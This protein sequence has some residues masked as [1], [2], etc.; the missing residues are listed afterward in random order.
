MYFTQ[1][2]IYIIID[3]GITSYSCVDVDIYMRL[4]TDLIQRFF[5]LSF[6]TF[7]LHDRIWEEWDKKS[8][9]IV[10]CLCQKYDHGNYAWVH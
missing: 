6:W 3:Y 4:I 9:I 7:D 2:L 1:F 8:F 10:T 5:S